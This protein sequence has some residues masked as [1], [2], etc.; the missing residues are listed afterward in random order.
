MKKKI[1]HEV[2]EGN[3][4]RKKIV[5]EG[6]KSRL[7]T[8]SDRA[9]QVLLAGY[10]AEFRQRFGPEMAQVF[11]ACCRAAF[12]SRGVRGVIGLW[13]PALWDWAQ[14]AAGE[15]LSRVTRRSPV[16]QIY[17][18]RS[19]SQ[20]IP[21]LFFL[22]A[23]LILVLINPCSWL[24]EGSF[25]Y[26][27]PRCGLGINNQ[28][29]KTLSLTPIFTGGNT[30]SAV[31]LFPNT[32]PSVSAAQRDIPV[33]AGE[34][35]FW[36]YDCS[37]QVVAALYACDLQGE[38]YVN[39]KSHFITQFTES[40]KDVGFTFTSLES[41]PRPEAALDAAVGSFPEHN[42]SGVKVLGLCILGIISV[43]GGIFTLA[44][45]RT[46]GMPKTNI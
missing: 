1:Q 15:W 17:K 30:F 20:I 2:L 7:L 19:A 22:N 10:P 28:S 43:I 24:L 34:K 13:L 11:R 6:N 23:C 4:G 9:Y 27:T 35:V 32:F 44:R 37:R 31:R 45:A 33:Q 29:G 14:S 18:R 16:Y 8:F 5:A 46:V 36:A 38:C 26:G 39:Q 42:Y 40:G 12:D 25:P 3:E 21:L 41:L